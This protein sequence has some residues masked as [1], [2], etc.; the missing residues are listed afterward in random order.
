METLTEQKRG[1]LTDRIREKSNE[2]LGYKITQ[3]EL[4]LLPY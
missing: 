2:L 4:R 3:Q 1:Q